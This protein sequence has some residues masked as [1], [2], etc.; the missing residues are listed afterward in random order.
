MSRA[1]VLVIGVALLSV[2]GC[3]W[4][5]GRPLEDSVVFQPRTYPN[6]DWTAEPGIED[7]WFESADGTRLHGWFA[8]ARAPRAVVLYAHGNAG[9]VSDWRFA[10]QLF[11][12][13]LNTSVL[14]F[15]Y[16]GYGRSEG[17][18]SE[19]GVLT[20][21]RAARRWLAARTNVREQDIV[22]VGRSLG[23]GVAVDLAAKDGARGLI[24]ES[25]F[26]SLPDTAASYFPLLPVRGL[27]RTRL[28]S[29]A[30]IPNYHGPLLQTH[31]DADRIVPYALGRKLFNAAN[32]PKLFVSVPGGGHNGPPSREY[33]TALDQFLGSL[34]AQN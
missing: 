27:M 23:G 14:V 6:G 17:T 32:E 1:T 25:T 22:L 4:L 9:N 24:L 29:L 2:V 21:A 11:R 8:E 15:D 34:P 30:K 16:R 10:L 28:D 26:T 20:D 13:R 33:L 5:G 3:T 18:P 19:A 31:G 12:D 7:A